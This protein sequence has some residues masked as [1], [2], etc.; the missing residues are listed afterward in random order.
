MNR[1]RSL[2]L[3][4]IREDIADADGIRVPSNTA[5]HL[6]PHDKHNSSVPSGPRRSDGERNGRFRS[7]RSKTFLYRL[8]RAKGEIDN[9]KVKHPV[10]RKDF[11]NSYTLVTNSLATYEVTVGKSHSCQCMD[12]SKNQ[13]KELCKHII[14]VLLYICRVPEES[15]LLQQLSLTDAECLEILSNTPPVKDT[16]KYVP[17][18]RRQTQ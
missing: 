5:S 13:G 14:W 7:K 17:G 8:Q 10:T 2:G 16:L 12:F 11:E 3:E 1:A 9:I 4:L 6:N 18:A 15:E